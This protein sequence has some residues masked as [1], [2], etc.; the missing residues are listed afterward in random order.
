M[1]L[2]DQHFAAVHCRDG[3]RKGCRYL[4]RSEPRQGPP[5]ISEHGRQCDFTPS[6][7][8][9]VAEFAVLYRSEMFPM[10]M[11]E[12]DNL[13]MKRDGTLTLPSRFEAHHPPLI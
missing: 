11:K 8:G 5:P 4:H 2:A 1:R 9:T 10:E 13:T 3:Y 7:D 12:V 6:G